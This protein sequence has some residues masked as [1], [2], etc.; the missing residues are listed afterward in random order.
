[1]PSSGVEACAV[2][3]DSEIRMPREAQLT[4]PLRSAAWPKLNPGKL[5][6]E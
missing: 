2:L 3:P 5:C 1:M 4:G 6:S